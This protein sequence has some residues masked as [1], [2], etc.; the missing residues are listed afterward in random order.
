METFTAILIF[1]AALLPVLGALAWQFFR[2]QP[3]RTAAAT[4]DC[5]YTARPLFNAAE[6]MVLSHLDHLCRQT[7][8]D[9]ARVMGQVSYGEFLKGSTRPGHARINQKRADFVICDRAGKVLCVFEYQGSG[10]FGRTA[11][12]RENAR[13]RDRVKREACA[14][15]GIPFIELPADLTLEVTESHFREGMAPLVARRA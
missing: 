12:D 2:P 7:F 9:E 14:A 10:H 11:R 5:R 6:R 13:E 8:G 15:A 4:D 3:A 1:T